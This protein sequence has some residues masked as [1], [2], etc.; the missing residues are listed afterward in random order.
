M[1]TTWPP[2]TFYEIRVGDTVRSLDHRTGD[3]IATGQVD[4][5]VHCK[6]HDRIL[7]YSLGLL[8]RSD[9]PIL[10]GR[11]HG[12]HHS[13]PCPQVPDR[14]F[15]RP[16]PMPLL[17]P[18]YAPNRGHPLRACRR[19]QAMRHAGKNRR[20]T[21]RRGPRRCRTDPIPHRSRCSNAQSH[22]STSTA[23]PLRLSTL[24]GES[25]LLL[26]TPHQP[27]HWRV[28]VLRLTSQSRHMSI[29]LIITVRI[30]LE[31]RISRHRLRR[32]G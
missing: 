14:F 6:N 16:G 32:C 23:P 1:S 25:L 3:V 7:S 19:V 9:Y 15:L 12:P 4:N 20:H 11:P 22:P 2:V 27:H 5:V 29:A 30:I 31:H 13:S 17:R 10:K 21:Y 26:R 28:P 18:R 8:A 24:A